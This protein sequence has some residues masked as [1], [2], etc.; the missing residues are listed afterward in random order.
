MW[1]TSS[2]QQAFPAKEINCTMTLGLQ[3]NLQKTSLPLTHLKCQFWQIVV[4]KKT[5]CCRCY[6]IYLVMALFFLLLAVVI[7]F[8]VY[9]GQ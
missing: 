6:L 4:Q 2:N 8:S 1:S 5:M 7:L 9:V 3:A